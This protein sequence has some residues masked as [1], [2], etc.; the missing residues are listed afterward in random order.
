MHDPSF[1]ALNLRPIRLDIW[2]DEPGGHDTH[3]VCGHPPRTRVARLLWT[4]RHARHLRYRWWPY[5]LIRRWIGDRCDGCG[6][7]FLWRDSRNSYQG[8]DKVWHDPCMSLRHAR[9]QLDDITNY[10]RGEADANARWRVEYRLK[11]IDAAG[12]TK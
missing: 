11:N 3:Q 6:R 5:L 4:V 7:R 2:H 12:S 8:T 10:L 1:L 9:G